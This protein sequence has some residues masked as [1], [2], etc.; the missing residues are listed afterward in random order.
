MQSA[1]VQV[2]HAVVLVGDRE[3]EPPAMMGDQLVTATEAV[4]AVG[5]VPDG[6]GSTRIVLAVSGEDVERPPHRAF[7]GRLVLPAGCLAVETVE[8]STIAEA[9]GLSTSVVVEVWTSDTSEPDEVLVS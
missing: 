4:I 5:T 2:P 8:G 9:S 3:A 6:D 7:S 1:V